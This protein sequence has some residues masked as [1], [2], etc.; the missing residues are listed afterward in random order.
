[1]TQAIPKPLTLNNFLTLPETTPASEFIDGKITQKPIP[2]GKHSRLQLK[3]CNTINAV[4]EG[5]Q[6]AYAFPELRCSFGTRSIVPDIAVFRWQNIALDD[7]GEP[8][9]NVTRPPDWTIEILSP[10]Q[11]QNRVVNNIVYCLQYGCRLGWLI[12]PADRSVAIYQPDQLPTFHEGPSPLIVPETIAL[13]ITAEQLF[14]LLK[15]N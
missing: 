9:D 5:S 3:L 6:I 12:D 15:M 14:N 8:L 13:A 11:A 10:D 1:M 4:T 2:K 7:D